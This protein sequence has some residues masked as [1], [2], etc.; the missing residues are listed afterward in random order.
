MMCKGSQPTDGGNLLFDTKE[1]V[2]QLV[3]AEPLAAKYIREFV[4]ADEFIKGKRRYCLWLVNANPSDLKKCP[5]IMRRVAAVRETRLKST[6]AATRKQAETPTLFTE[7]RQPGGTYVV[8][9]E[10]SSEK[11]RYVPIGFMDEKNCM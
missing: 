7:I 8:V 10:V 3:K 11:R 2:E 6:K 4:G 5:E 9:P 1:S